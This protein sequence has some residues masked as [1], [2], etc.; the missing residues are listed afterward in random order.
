MKKVDKLLGAA[1]ARHDAAGVA[2][3]VAAGADPN[4]VD[5]DGIPALHAAALLG[6]LPM[7]KALLSN[8]AHIDAKDPH[9]L[10]A[11]AWLATTGC[12]PEHFAV[13]DELV[14]ADADLNS[15]NNRGQR[16]ID[17]AI[18]FYNAPMAERLVNAGADVN[19][20]QRARVDEISQLWKESSRTR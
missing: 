18:G 2:K 16:P 7:V 9:G 5:K 13:F 20:E 6:D 12:T 8:N 17:G 14:R 11:L 1:L 10:T 4:Q 3:A 15:Q 19:K